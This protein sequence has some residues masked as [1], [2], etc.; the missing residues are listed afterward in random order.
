MENKTKENKIASLYEV[1]DTITFQLGEN[2]YTSKG[3]YYIHLEKNPQSQNQ[4]ILNRSSF[5]IDD[6]EV[7]KKFPKISNLYFSSIFPLI[8]THHDGNYLIAEFKETAK[9]IM[10]HDQNIR[11]NYSGD[12]LEYIREQFLNRVKNQTDFKDFIEQLPLYQ[13]LN[14]SASPKFKKE[15]FHFKWNIAGLGIIEGIG[16]F[17]LTSETNKM[18]FILDQT[19]KTH[20]IELLENYIEENSIL[21]PLNKDL[22]IPEIYFSM[23][24]TYSDSLSSILNAK[25]ELQITIGEKFKYNQTFFLTLSPTNN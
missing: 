17:K 20:F 5:R 6:K 1:E 10:E 8:L 3:S 23:Q 2:N 7:E 24:T 4:I 22:D 12:G 15:Q 21:T 11:N 9:R 16:N 19:D 25:A 14:I 18:N 13:I